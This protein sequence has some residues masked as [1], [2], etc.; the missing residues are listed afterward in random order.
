METASVTSDVNALQISAGQQVCAIE[1]QFS[2]RGLCA[3][4]KHDAEEQERQEE[5]TRASEP[6][7]YRLSVLPEGVVNGKYRGGK[8]VMSGEDLLHYFYDTRA[9]RTREADF[10]ST[11]ATDDS[12]RS[13]ESEKACRFVVKTVETPTLCGSLAALP[14]KLLSAPRRAVE[15][16][17]TTHGEWFDASPADTRAETRRFPLSALAAIFAVAMSL[18]LI[19]ASSVMVHQGESRVNSLTME[20]DGEMSEVSKIRSDLDVKTDLLQIREVAVEDLGMVDKSYI[21]MNYLT[22][23]D[24]D[25][26]EV[27]ETEEEESL[28]FSALLSAI[29]LK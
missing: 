15:A 7:S 1:A 3:A 11:P 22:V 20:V 14:A 18:L 21:R 9:L 2:A 5:E 25:S 8:D 13:G 6:L 23:G 26:I 17:R 4:V 16:I 29:G 12:I 19:V 24:E 10:A 27:Y 28:G